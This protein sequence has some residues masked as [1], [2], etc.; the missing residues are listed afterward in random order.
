MKL[1]YKSIDEYLRKNVIWKFREDFIAY[2]AWNAVR[3]CV[4]NP[5]RMSV[6]QTNFTSLRMTIKNS[7]NWS[8]YET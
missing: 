6:G 7:S 1:R 3:N 8:I 2:P 5:V 4:L